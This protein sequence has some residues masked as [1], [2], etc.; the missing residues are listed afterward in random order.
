MPP[1][2]EQILL[3][4]GIEDREVVYHICNHYR[5]DNRSLFAIEAK[6]GYERLR[7][8]LR[9]RP[10][11][12]GMKAIG[13]VVDADEDLPHRW[14][15]LRDTLESAGYPNVP[16]APLAE[17]IILPR[18][19]TLPRMGIWLM[20]DNQIAG[21]LEDFLQKLI[22]RGDVLLPWALNSVERLP[23]RRFKPTYRSKA[24][25]HTW[26]AW[27]E[28]PGTP[29]GQAMTKHYLHADHELAQRFITWVKNLFAP[30]S[31]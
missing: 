15:S 27:Q 10:R 28:E 21:I 14:Q 19:D 3:V 25:I 11:T 5:L 12:F 22:L 7:D 23:E 24:A 16:E 1:K 8:D 9:V 18:H 20:P 29:L 13:A 26:L 30:T 31:S 4:E 17:G 6:D 2:P